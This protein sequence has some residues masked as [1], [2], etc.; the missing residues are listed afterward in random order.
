MK[1]LFVAAV[2]IGIGGYVGFET[3]L[4][5]LDMHTAYLMKVKY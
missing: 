3:V 5:V 4:T 2:I 1:A